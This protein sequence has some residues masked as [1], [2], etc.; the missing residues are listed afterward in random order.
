MLILILILILIIILIR[1]K[2]D[3]LTYK[4]QALGPEHRVIILGQHYHHHYHSNYYYRYWWYQVL[5]LPLFFIIIVIT[6]IIVIIIIVI[7]IIMVGST[8]FPENGE[9]KDYKRYLSH[10]YI[11]HRYRRHHYDYDY[12]HYFYDYHYRCHYYQVF[13]IS[14]CIFHILIM[15]VG[16][17]SPKNYTNICI[18]TKNA[19]NTKTCINIDACYGNLT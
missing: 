18:H 9:M 4:N 12:R 8:K 1:F 7:I 13:S 6:I 11:H 14:F 5:L 2:K 19:T 16:N 15:L 3:L 10:Y 17:S